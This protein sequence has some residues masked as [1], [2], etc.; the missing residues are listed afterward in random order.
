[1]EN[2]ERKGY[3]PRETKAGICYSTTYR[4]AYFLPYTPPAEIRSAPESTEEKTA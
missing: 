4:S 2:S 1:M 3:F